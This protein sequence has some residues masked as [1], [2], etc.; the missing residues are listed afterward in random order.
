V[1]VWTAVLIA[2]AGVAFPVSRIPRL[3]IVA[4]AADLLML[5]P[6]G[7]VALRKWKSLSA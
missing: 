3:A 7:Y 1:P 6:M 2:L 5:V 4:H